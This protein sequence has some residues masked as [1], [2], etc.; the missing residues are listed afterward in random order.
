MAHS[1]DHWLSYLH[2][3]HARDVELGLERIRQVWQA[4]D[5]PSPAPCV[6][7]VGGTNGKGSTVALLQAMLAA[8]GRRVGTYT[9]PHLIRYTERVQIAGVEVSAE[10][11]CIA[12]E[13]IEQA[14]GQV[15]LTYFEFGTLA[16]LL[17]FA[18]ADLDVAVL[19]V[20]LGGRLDAVNLLDADASIVTTVA[21]DHQDW[22]GTN[23]DSIGREKAG[24]FRAGRPALVGDC[25]PP[26]GLIATAAT[27]Q[28]D[29]IR[30]GVAFRATAEGENWRFLY[31]NTDL[32]L[33]WPALPGVRQLDNAAVA[34]ACLHALRERLGWQPEALAAGLRSVRLAGRLQVLADTPQLLVD[35]AHN[36]QAAQVLASWLRDHPRAG[37]SV[38]VFSALA[39][40]DIAGI[41][42][43][44]HALI[45]TWYVVPILDAG[46]RGLDAA[47]VAARL[48]EVVGG[49][50]IRSHDDLSGAL[51]AARRSC[52]VSDRIVVFGSFHVVGA[53][54]AQIAAEAA[55]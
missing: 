10:D 8:S 22:L 40:K 1:L 49:E 9:S 31:G 16:A 27:M 46:P 36:P 33:P 54:L 51:V 3:L 50:R 41:A 47:S 20:G 30:A 4:L 18:E 14:R 11:F 45:G 39:D 17:L 34:V 7:S 6:I 12:F 32:L 19:E 55:L 48:G 43:V 13:R 28:V 37:H 29:L 24:I 44:L 26:N 35:V 42:Q 23:R 52:C 38:A 15:T 25:A 2:H 5:A 21:L 53:L